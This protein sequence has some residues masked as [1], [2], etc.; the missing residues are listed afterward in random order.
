M[1]YNEIKIKVPEGYEE[2]VMAY[3][4]RKVESIITQ[5]TLKPTE[6]MK[7]D[8]KEKLKELKTINKIIIK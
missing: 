4:L 5:L 7:L 2:Q 8:Y 1:K 6:T 3:A